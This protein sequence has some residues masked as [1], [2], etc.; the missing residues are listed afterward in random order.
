MSPIPGSVMGGMYGPDL[1]EGESPVHSWR[2][3][4]H[5][6]LQDVPVVSPASRDDGTPANLE[7][8]RHRVPILPQT[9]TSRVVNWHNSAPGKP[10]DFNACNS[11]H[12]PPVCARLL[13]GGTCDKV[14]SR[15]SSGTFQTVDNPLCVTSG[16][17]I[18]IL[19]NVCHLSLKLRS[20]D[21]RSEAS[22]PAYLTNWT[23]PHAFKDNL[24]Q[25][26]ALLVAQRMFAKQFEDVNFVVP[27]TEKPRIGFKE[28]YSHFDS[29]CVTDPE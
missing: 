18:R 20:A 12:C 9:P 24:P 22:V 6:V 29:C 1:F 28:P 27:R 7:E 13:L 17:T 2:V 5:S 26:G 4:R 8:T 3:G 19:R 11:R 21:F 14:L 16:V 10:L 15:L 25:A 23:V